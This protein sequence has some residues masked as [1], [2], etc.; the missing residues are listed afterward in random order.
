M[1][2]ALTVLLAEREFLK[3]TIWVSPSRVV[4]LGGNVT[5]RC[6]GRHRSMKFF[7]RK[8]G[9]TNPQVETVPNG[10]VA[11]FP[12][13]SV[14][15]GDGGSYTCDY[16]SIM[17]QNRSSLPSDPVKIIV[18][19]PSY[20]K[21]NISLSC[22]GGVSL[23]GIVAVWCRVQHWVQHRGV[24]FVLNKERRHF[25][26]VDSDRL[27]VVF[28]ISNVRWEDSGNYSCSYHSRSEPFAVSY[29]S[30]SV[31][32]VV[33]EPSYLKPSISLRP[34]GRVA[35]GGAVTIRCECRCPGARFLLS[36]AGDPDTQRTIY[37]AGDMA[38]FPI[39]NVSRGDAGSYCCRYSTKWDPPDW[40]E[41]SD[42]VELVVA[43][44]TRGNIIR[45][46]LSAVVL[47]ALALILAEAA[48]DWR[49]GT[50]YMSPSTPRK[51]FLPERPEP[52]GLALVYGPLFSPH[53]LEVA[54]LP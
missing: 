47:L 32:L 20:P 30:D 38:E 15:R 22:S 29:P 8:A 41:P 44:Y 9:H 23:G 10:T 49:R 46:A 52:A 51:D 33:R 35:P 19:E 54:P 2:S 7:L 31:E 37:S 50:G 34:S 42:P 25:P 40:S 21:S 27:G 18:G 6:E 28:S 4:A 53:E 26:P 16:H 48:H 5:I 17:E 13:P 39:H 1:A 43:D 45:L 11:E 14:S 3:P 36:K 24:R 12:I